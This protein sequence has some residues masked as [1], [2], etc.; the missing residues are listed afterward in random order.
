MILWFAMA[1]AIKSGV[2]VIE[3]D[4]HYNE[5]DTPKTRT[6]QFEWAMAEEYR[7]KAK[8]EYSS[9]QFQAAELLAKESIA[10]MDKATEKS[11]SQDVEEDGE[12][13]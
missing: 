1:C 9:S 11:R 2:A 8:E 4:K 7:L 6:A 13:Q 3:M 10:W 12:S 5:L